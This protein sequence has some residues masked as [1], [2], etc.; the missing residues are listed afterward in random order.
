M[1]YLATVSNE[2][3]PTTTKRNA[4]EGQ[5]NMIENLETAKRPELVKAAVDTFGKGAAGWAMFQSND[6]LREAIRTGTPPANAASVG[7]AAPQVATSAPASAADLGAIIAAAVAPH[8][9]AAV[10]RDTVASMIEEALASR[11][12]TRLEIITPKGTTTR[13]GEH[14]D[15]PDVLRAMSAGVNLWL[16]GPAGSGKTTIVE[17]AAETLGRRFFPFSCGPQMSQHALLG[18]M[19]AAGNY[20]RT[21]FREAYENGGVFLFDEADAAS[22]SVLTVINSALA[23]GKCSFPDKVVDRHP[24]FQ[25]VGAGNTWGTGADR[26]YVGRAQLDAATLDRF[27]FLTVDYDGDLE[28][29]AAGADEWTSF[30]QSARDAAQALKVRIV[31]SPRASINGARLLAAGMDRAKVETAALWKGADADTVAK[32]RANMG[33]R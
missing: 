30:V 21:L 18:Y 1:L 32:I 19:D 27:V 29:N 2:Q 17:H 3:Q 28:R 6:A 11:A 4:Q 8:I 12:G 7:N 24:E 9:R 22:P 5:K 33:D 10:D 25:A 20:V 16:V 13:E 14:K 15:F 31:I 26:Q 23:N